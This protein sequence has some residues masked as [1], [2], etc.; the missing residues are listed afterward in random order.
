VGNK[1]E[2]RLDYY[3]G[4]RE[5]TLEHIKATEEG[6]RKLKDVK[7]AKIEKVVADL[8]KRH[9]KLLKRIERRIKLETTRS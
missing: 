2:A 6:I 3:K 9:E 4:V 8:H 1:R 7:P 5:A